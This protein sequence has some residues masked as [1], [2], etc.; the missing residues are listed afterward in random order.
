MQR[1]QRMKGSINP[2]EEDQK[3]RVMMKSRKISYTTVGH[4]GALVE[5]IAF[6]R[7]VV[8]S[9]PALAVT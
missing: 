8:G 4:G 1:I 3:N 9:P 5:S 2:E 7:R 6:N